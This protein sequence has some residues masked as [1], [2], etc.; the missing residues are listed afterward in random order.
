MAHFTSCLCIRARSS[1]H[2][3]TTI[4]TLSLVMLELLFLPPACPHLLPAAAGFSESNPVLY[5]NTNLLLF[6][7]THRVNTCSLAWWITR[8][9]ASSG[10]SP[11]PHP[12]PPPLPLQRLSQITHCSLVPA[13]Q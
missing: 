5:L 9:K 8:F 11:H 13:M 6:S 2:L 4:F 7:T 3:V 12:L 10:L 1:S